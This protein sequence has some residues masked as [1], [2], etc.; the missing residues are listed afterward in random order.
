MQ[1]QTCIITRR[2]LSL[3]L[4]LSLSRARYSSS[5]NSYQL[6][7]RSIALDCVD[8]RQH[9]NQHKLPCMRIMQWTIIGETELPFS[10]LSDSCKLVGV[11]S[12]C[13]WNQNVHFHYAIVIFYQ[14]TNQ[15]PNHSPNQSMKLPRHVTYPS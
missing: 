9:H 6:S 14:P 8:P 3:S 10:I 12:G 13:G 1:W 15:P 2:T 5:L 4:S 7:T 11:K